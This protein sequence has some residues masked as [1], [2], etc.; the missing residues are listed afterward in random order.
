MRIVCALD[1]LLWLGYGQFTYTPYGYFTGAGEVIALVPGKLPWMIRV[2]LSHAS[3]DNVTTPEPC[4]HFME[5][6]I[7]RS[8]QSHQ[9]DLRFTASWWWLIYMY[10]G[11]LLILDMSTLIWAGS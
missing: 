10:Q 11:A 4:L 5:R 6:A 8:H 9:S 7:Q 2:H 3:I 1:V